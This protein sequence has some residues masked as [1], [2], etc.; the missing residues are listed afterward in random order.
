MKKMLNEN[1]LRYFIDDKSKFM[2]DLTNH[3]KSRKYG[4]LGQYTNLI[5]GDNSKLWNPIVCKKT[6]K[7]IDRIL[8]KSQ[9]YINKHEHT[10]LKQALKRISKKGIKAV[11]YAKEDVF[12]KI[13]LAHESR[14]WPKIEDFTYITVDEIKHVNSPQKARAVYEEYKQQEILQIEK[15][16]KK[17]KKAA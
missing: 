8:K 6:K 13:P 9:K 3:L 7:Q 16:L 10:L 11:V 2:D 17:L 15:K 4:S 1:T 12:V 14:Y 5:G